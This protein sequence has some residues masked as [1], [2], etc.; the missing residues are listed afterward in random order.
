MRGFFVTGTDTG[1]GK[2]LVTAALA[3]A[4]RHQGVSVGV[5]KPVETGVTERHAS[6]AVRLQLAAG[7]T[8]PTDLVSPYPLPEPLAPLAAARVMGLE[9]QREPVQQAFRTLSSRHRYMLVE[10]IGG[11]RVPI[12]EKYEVLDVIRDFG[13]PVVVVGRTAIGGVNHAL[14]TLEALERRGIAVVA[15]VA[16]PTV[17]VEKPGHAQA[18]ST[19]T[20]LRQAAVLPVLGPLLYASPAQGWSSQVEILAGDPAILWLSSQLTAAET[21]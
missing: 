3:A 14:L 19:V 15:L 18:D 5:M 12:S 20:L 8:D 6:D 2:T 7:T 21:L 9:I 1:V 17:P 11:V 13:L 10:G 16:N 4:L